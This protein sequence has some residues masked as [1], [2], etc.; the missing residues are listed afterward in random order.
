[1]RPGQLYIVLTNKSRGIIKEVDTS[2]V[3]IRWTHGPDG[4][5][6]GEGKPHSYPP[7]ECR[8]SLESV[9]VAVASDR[10]IISDPGSDPNAIF[11]MRKYNVHRKD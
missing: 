2:S 4:F 1:M 5:P 9:E 8:Y 7:S 11:L 6:K 3:V 10:V